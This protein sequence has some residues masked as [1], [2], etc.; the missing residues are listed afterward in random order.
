MLSENES[1]DP[2]SIQNTWHILISAARGGSVCMDAPVAKR[3]ISGQWRP[4]ARGVLAVS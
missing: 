2:V 4:P 3:L 1:L